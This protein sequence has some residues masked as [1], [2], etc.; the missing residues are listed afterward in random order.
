MLTRSDLRRLLVDARF[1]AGAALLPPPVA[2]FQIRARQ[3]ARRTDDVFSLSSA[4]RPAD[5]R[6]LLSVARGRRRVVELGTATGW[7][8][9][10][11]ALA[12]PGRSVLSCDVVERE[13]PQR[14]LGLVSG[15]TRARIE[16][17]LRPGS[18]G[19]VDDAP[20]D[21]LY[22]DSSHEREQTIDEVQ[23]WRPV[24]GPGAVIV[25]DDYTHPDFPG[26]SQAVADLGLTGE[27][28]GTLFVHRVSRLPK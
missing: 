3:L 18:A 19:P 1:D 21:L 11:L 7:T 12:D 28:R 14:Y 23:A 5:L 24:L 27:Q 26:V 13:E 10:S 16:L 6:T 2:R 22:I 20:V 17:A 9:I 15:A 8:A 4:T 25:F